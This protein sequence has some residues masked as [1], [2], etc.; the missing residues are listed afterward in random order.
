MKTAILFLNIILFVSCSFQKSDEALQLYG[1][2]AQSIITP[3]KETFLIEPRGKKS[4]GTHDELYVKALALGD[5]E[6]KFVIVSF[7]LIGLDDSLV[8]R[9]HKAVYDLTGI[10]PQQLMLNTSHTHSSPITLNAMDPLP[11]EMD[12]GESARNKKWENQMVVTTA[13]TVETAVTNMKKVSV[14]HGK[15][16]VQVGFNRR[17]SLS[18]K[19]SM[20]PNPFG[21]S[22]KNTDAVYVNHENS[23]MAV[24]FSYA[25]HPV[26][27]HSTSTEFSADYPGYACEFIERKFPH[28]IPMFL[29]GCAGNINS[30]L[31]GGYEAALLDGNKLGNAVVKSNQNSQ[32]INSAAIYYDQRNFYLP[33]LDLNVNVAELILKRM[34]ESYKTLNDSNADFKHTR[35]QMDFINWAH[36]LKDIAENQK[37][38]PGLPFQAKAV[39]LGKS[40]VIIALPDEVFVDYAIYLKEHSPFEQ[41]IVL[42]YTDGCRSYIPSA[43]AFYL[44]GYEPGYAQVAYGQPYLRPVCE[45]II[46]KK[47]LELLADL[48]NRY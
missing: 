26:C 27:V 17:L 31:K 2:V 8:S 16:P 1:N 12:K 48:W 4:T 42:G 19:A 13:K 32:K 6:N 11:E 5:G 30:T 36:R 29:Q 15:Y 39:A 23:V 45:E 14:S 28:S 24:I 21:P 9:I 22:L 33:F 41:T 43:E 35:S 18:F 44:G 20:K 47:S 25:A 34:D 37:S 3:S 10:N 40:L 46:K 7:D 38:Q